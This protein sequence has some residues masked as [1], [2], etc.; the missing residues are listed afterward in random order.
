MASPTVKIV[1]M[2]L[3]YNSETSAT[4]GTFSKAVSDA[5]GSAEAAKTHTSYFKAGSYVFAV[6]EIFTS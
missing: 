5:I 6:I 4:A 3:P 2:R 1:K